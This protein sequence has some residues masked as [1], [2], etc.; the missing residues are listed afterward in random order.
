MG[1]ALPSPVLSASP[2]LSFAFPAPFF[3]FPAKAGAYASSAK[4]Y[5]KQSLMQSFAFATWIPAFA[6][7]ACKGWGKR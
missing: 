6:G 2:T 1:A 7:K 4:T 5:E 3:A